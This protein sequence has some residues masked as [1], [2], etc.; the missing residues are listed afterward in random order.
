MGNCGTKPKTSEGD[1][2]PAPAEPRTPAGPSEGDRKDEEVAAPGEASQA[3]VAP[4][5]E[6]AT[7]TAAE[8]K[9]DG[10]PKEEEAV[11]MEDADQGKEKET[12]TTEAAGELP[13]SAPASVA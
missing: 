1:D 9:E 2:A 5:S 4:R 12:P 6:E 11:P 10:E 13:A 7:T 8:T 3:V